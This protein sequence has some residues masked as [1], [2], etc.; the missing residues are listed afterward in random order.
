MD[1]RIYEWRGRTWQFAAGEQPDD[2]VEA[3]PERKSKA[4]ANKSRQAQA[5]EQGKE[6]AKEQ[7]KEQ[8]R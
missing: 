3:E 5:K 2:A 4:P 6:Q 7:A 8:R 1:L